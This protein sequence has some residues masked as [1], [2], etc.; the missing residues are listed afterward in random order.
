MESGINAAGILL[1][2]ALATELSTARGSRRPSR[3]VVL[4]GVACLAV[5]PWLRPENIALT[6]L[7]V[8]AV[9]SRGLRLRRAWA[10]ILLIPGGLMTLLYALAAG[11]PLG[12]GAV[13]K[14][15]LATPYLDGG[16]L[17]RLVGLNW[18]LAL[19][20]LYAGARPH[21]L[22]PG[23]GLLAV[24]GVV[25]AF[26]RRF[27]QLRPLAVTWVVLLLLAP[28]S[29]ILMWQRARHH[30]AGIACA[31][32]LATAVL[33]VGTERLA[34]R[35]RWLALLLP[36]AMLTDL[37]YWRNAYARSVLE[38]RHRHGPAV[39][40]LQQN[41]R[42][43]ILVL[44]D[45]GLPALAHDGPMVDVMGL[46]TP[47]FALPHRH[48]AGAVAE[49]LARL[50][51]PPTIAAANL[52]VFRVPQ[53]LAPGLVPGLDPK[54]Q[55]VIA[56]VRTELLERT[57][58]ASEGVDLASLG[59]EAEARLRWRPEPIPLHASLALVLED[60]GGQTMQGCRPLRGVLTLEVP[61]G[62]TLRLRAA[63]LGRESA[64]VRT[65]VAPSSREGHLT[66]TL[67]PGRWSELA[68][69]RSALGILQVVA[70]PGPPACLEAIAW[71]GARSDSQ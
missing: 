34:P 33:A 54:R 39:A 24:I 42:D 44:N 63:S 62:V 2:A 59:S 17:A 61:P 21:L 57:V 29:T 67:P 45:A 47:V 23:I 41:A 10:P 3:G 60:E 1:A 6:L 65:S 68:L 43:E 26:R 22:A 36:L 20:P 16:L 35:L 48:G 9:C 30:H 55:T 37:P 5:L 19:G 8:V 64:V 25:L 13:T 66:H 15:V 11:Q 4:A 18:S 51:A 71:Q 53:L 58:L 14:S 69:G 56:P 38:I 40:W 49:A 7:A 50:P 27:E 32:V 12:A 70:Q 52:D 46:G 31:L 28:L